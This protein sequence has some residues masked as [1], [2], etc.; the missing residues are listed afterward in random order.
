[1]VPTFVP[2]DPRIPI[3]R[4]AATAFVAPD[5][6]RTVIGQSIQL[7]GPDGGIRLLEAGLVEFGDELVVHGR[8]DELTLTP[9][10]ILPRTAAPRTLEIRVAQ[11]VGPDVT[12]VSGVHD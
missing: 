12:P 8:H 1:V 5:G 3:E 9:M 2:D 11:P 6:T 10:S 7:F 4:G